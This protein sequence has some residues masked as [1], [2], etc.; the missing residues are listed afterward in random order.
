MFQFITKRSFIVNAF[1]AVV[2]A[3]AVLFAFFQL[4]DYITQ[5]GKYLKVP[6][7]KGKSIAEARKILEAQG[8]EV[9]VQD[10]VYY[11]SLPKLSIVKQTP[12]G[13]DLVKINRTVYLTVN[14]AQPPLLTMPNFVGQTLKSVEMQVKALGFKIGDTTYKPDFA[15]GS[16]LEQFYKGEVINPGTKIPMGSSIS[17]VIGGG[18]QNKEFTVPDLVGLTFDA[19]KLQLE[20]NGLLLGAIVI[21]G[22]VRDSASA[23]VIQ[24]SPPRRDEEGRPIRIRSGQL[25]DLWISSDAPKK[26]T[27]QKNTKTNND[28]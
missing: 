3:F 14:R 21:D 20:E 7:V 26:D 25:M 24:Q 22:I 12:A 10:S 13:D 27:V 4:L 23:F 1:V 15:V 18:V 5:H 2:L 28:Y 17:L 16:V 9:Q 6:T 19:A 8:F 11:D